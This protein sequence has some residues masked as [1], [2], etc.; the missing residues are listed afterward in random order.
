M[1]NVNNIYRLAN[2][3]KVRAGACFLGTA[4][5]RQGTRRYNEIYKNSEIRRTGNIPAGPGLSLPFKGL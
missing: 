5:T 4:K 3:L 2:L 1:A